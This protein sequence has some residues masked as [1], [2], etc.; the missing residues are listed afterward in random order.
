M[1]ACMRNAASEI[2]LCMSHLFF[3]SVLETLQVVTVPIYDEILSHC[4]LMLYSLVGWNGK[5]VRGF[6]ICFNS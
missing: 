3:P 6:F 2:N 5:I 4:I 1:H